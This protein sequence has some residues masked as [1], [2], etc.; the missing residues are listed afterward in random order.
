MAKNSIREYDTTAANN[1]DIGG[2]ASS[3]SAKGSKMD[4]L[5]RELASH[6]ADMNAGN[7][8][9]HD[10]FTL[11]DPTDDTKRFR[12]DVAGVSASTTRVLTVPDTDVAVTVF[13]ASL[14]DDADAAAA[15][16]TMGLVIGADVQ[17]H[18]AVLDATTA[19]FTTAD[20]TKLDGI[21][22]SA[23]VTDTANVTAAGAVMD[24][25]LTDE[26]AVKA[27]DQGLATTDNV[28]F[29][30]IEV[31]QQI[32]NIQNDL[33]T[34]VSGGNTSNNGFNI[35]MYGP[36][37]SSLAN[38]VRFRSGTTIVYEYDDSDPTHTWS[39]NGNK[40]QI[41]HSNGDI[42][43]LIFNN[44]AGGWLQDQFVGNNNQNYVNVIGSRFVGTAYQNTTGS[45]IQVFVK[46]AHAGITG[47]SYTFQVSE[48]GV[49]YHT[50]G[51]STGSADFSD[52]QVIVPNGHYYRLNAGN[53]A[54]WLELR[55]E[56]PD[57]LN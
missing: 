21:E 55:G 10:T 53:I 28:T 51:L 22:A 13:G 49:T 45:P 34:S 20:E 36:T 14:L 56:S 8:P 11:A 48:D 44:G 38:D 46:F 54:L 27:I 57:G 30:L 35:R 12:I 50:I 7:E 52:V 16:T 24:S 41:F 5:I 4:D 19:S 25:E 37:H 3:G 43:G 17:A 31:N 15:R 42:W 2:V 47:P 39:L 18:S 29:Q 40:T 6:L 26:A 23:D 32:R 1:T 33:F 9:I